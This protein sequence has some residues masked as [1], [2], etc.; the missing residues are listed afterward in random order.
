MIKIL[1]PIA[2]ATDL[3]QVFVFENFAYLVITSHEIKK[4]PIGYVQ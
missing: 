4:N 2:E 3:K 1:T